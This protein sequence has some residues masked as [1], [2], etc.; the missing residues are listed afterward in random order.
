MS[1]ACPVKHHGLLIVTPMPPSDAMLEYRLYRTTKQGTA[2]AADDPRRQ[3][4]FGSQ[5]QTPARLTISTAKK[6][7]RRA[8]SRSN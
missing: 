2:I 6:P 7:I 8:S 4:N 5:T 3:L 1:T